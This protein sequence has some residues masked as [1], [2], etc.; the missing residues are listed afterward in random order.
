MFNEDVR[1]TGGDNDGLVDL[2]GI[3]L[4]K[5]L[6]EQRRKESA[7]ESGEKKEN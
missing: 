4:F 3:M 6:E 1:F 7:E 2:Q 5:Y